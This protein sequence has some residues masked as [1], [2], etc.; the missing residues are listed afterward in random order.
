MTT[1][2]LQSSHHLRPITRIFW[3]G[4]TIGLG[5]IPS[6]LFF[7]WVERNMALPF[8]IYQ[9][10]GAPWINLAESSTAVKLIWN[11]GLFLGFGFFHSLFAQRAP[12]NFIRRFI[13][14]QCVRGFYVV[15]SGVSTLAM[16]ACWQSTGVIVWLIPGLSAPVLSALSVVVYYAI[17]LQAQRVMTLFDPLEFVGL[18]QI[19]SRPDELDRM[20]AAGALLETGIYSRVRHP[21]YFFTIAAF[22]FAPMMSLDRALILVATVAYLSVGIPIEERKLEAKFGQ[23]YR[24]YKTRVPAVLPKISQIGSL[25]KTG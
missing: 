10:L 20:V 18:R 16:I 9:W 12:Q 2:M 14:V 1:V 17:L 3:A 19:Y 13:P 5:I 23:S 22:L 6:L 25:F 15:F 11:F 7:A 21:I 24:S 4:L 8:G